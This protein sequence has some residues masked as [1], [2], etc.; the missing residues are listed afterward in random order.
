M[1][2]VLW[3]VFPK[4]PLISGRVSRIYPQASARAKRPPDG[5][6]HVRGSLVGGPWYTTAG[7]YGKAT[8][9]YVSVARSRRRRWVSRT[10]PVCREITGKV[11]ALA[12]LHTTR[13]APVSPSGA[14][15]AS[16]TPDR[17]VFIAAMMPVLWALLRRSVVELIPLLIAGQ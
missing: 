12:R 11:S 3:R 8:V 17:Y 9:V 6:A 10:S 5:G 13:P 1:I 15:S 16:P 7:V 14:S 4:K 2:V